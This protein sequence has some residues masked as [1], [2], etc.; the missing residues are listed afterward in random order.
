[1][2]GKKKRKFLHKE[3]F[4]RLVWKKYVDIKRLSS[5]DS[6]ALLDSV[7]SNDEGDIENIMNDSDTELVAK[8]GS[9]ISTNII[10]KEEIGDQSSSVL[11]P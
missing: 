8:D 10:I 5:S 9:V 6:S 1:M 11:V 7:E 3:T 4:K 2:W